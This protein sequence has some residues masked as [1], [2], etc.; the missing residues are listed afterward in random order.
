[1]DQ[2]SVDRL[3][4]VAPVKN[5]PNVGARSASTKA[6]RILVCIIFKAKVNFSNL[7][8]P[9]RHRTK[10]FFEPDEVN[11][12]ATLSKKQQPQHPARPTKPAPPRH[13]PSK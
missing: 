9:N 3:H 5:I 13:N 6:D 1:M 10:Q 12:E 8:W 4:F 2:L 11:M 7:Q